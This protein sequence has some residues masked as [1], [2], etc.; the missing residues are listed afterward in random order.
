M[1]NP[2]LFNSMSKSRIVG[3]QFELKMPAVIDG[4]KHLRGML[5]SP[6]CIVSGCLDAIDR[7]HG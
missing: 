7:V 5:A 3:D 1:A 4:E 2:F 6:P